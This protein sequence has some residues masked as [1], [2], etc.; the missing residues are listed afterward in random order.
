MYDAHTIR[1]VVADDHPVVR[2]GIVTMLDTASDIE[3]I[4]VAASAEDAVALAEVERP[5]VLLM[6][7]RMPQMG[8]I[9]ATRRI[10]RAHPATR[11]LILTT[12]SD[13]LDIQRALGAGAAG[14]MLKDAE[15]ADVCA[16]IRAVASGES[17]LAP[18]I[19]RRVV[20]Q[21]TTPNG[22][23]LSGREI[24]ALRLLATGAEN[25]EIARAMRLSEA[26]VKSHLLHIFAKLGVSDRTAAVVTALA[27]G[28]ITLPET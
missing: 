26:T 23:T 27:H 4:G 3:I 17:Y 16:A 10:V 12:Y 13:D 8:G 14:Y 9:E 5:D 15:W 7:L 20:A 19:A 6:D 28:I 1:L 25:K 24:E 2:A 21:L 11:V 22:G 18:A